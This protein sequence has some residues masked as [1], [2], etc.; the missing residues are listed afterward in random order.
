MIAKARKDAEW[1]VKKVRPESPTS[2]PASMPREEAAEADRRV[3]PGV[4]Y[5]PSEG[6]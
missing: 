1:V 4:Q 2:L 5:T 3:G 6:K